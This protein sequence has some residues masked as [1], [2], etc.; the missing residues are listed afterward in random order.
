MRIIKILLVSI[1]LIL[2]IFLGGAFLL[3]DK[4][5]FT[6]TRI[7]NTDPVA[8]YTN[9]KDTARLEGILNEVLS[10]HSVN[11]VLAEQNEFTEILYTVFVDEKKESMDAGFILNEEDNGTE[12]TAYIRIDS[13]K[14]P[15]ERWKGFFIPIIYKKPVIKILNKLESVITN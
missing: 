13:L 1:L 12:I 11:I 3:P 9:L 5:Y 14:Y 8:V 4:Q 6:E 15:I 7:I 10:G 2:V